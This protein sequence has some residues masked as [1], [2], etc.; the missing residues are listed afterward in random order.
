[1][2][3]LLEF[4]LG[5]FKVQ[6]LHIIKIVMLFLATVPT[7]FVFIYQHKPNLIIELDILKLLIF[8]S[9]ITIPVLLYFYLMM[10][11]INI[12][13]SQ[14]NQSS[15]YWVNDFDFI[16]GALMAFLIFAASFVY[17]VKKPMSAILHLIV[18]WR[19]CSFATAGMFLTSFI[20]MFKSQFKKDK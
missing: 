15:K 18:V 16:F 1:M 10:S 4:L 12:L 5:S 14:Y 6:Q 3:K 20:S 19:L 7:G 13:M 2:D 17:Q 8:S 11:T 9:I